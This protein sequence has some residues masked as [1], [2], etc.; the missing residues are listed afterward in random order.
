M[1]L[2]PENEDQSK[3]MVIPVQFSITSTIRQLKEVLYR[4]ESSPRYLIVKTIK[5][6]AAHSGQAEQ[7]KSTLTV[8]GFMKKPET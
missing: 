5:V 4:I 6:S 3:Y 1:L 2:K 7:I 8:A